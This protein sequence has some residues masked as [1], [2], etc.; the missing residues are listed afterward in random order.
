MLAPSAQSQTAREDDSVATFTVKA[1]FTGASKDPILPNVTYDPN[2]LAQQGDIVRNGNSFEVTFKTLSGLGANKYSSAIAFRLCRD[3]KCGTVYPGS[4]QSFTY[5]LDVALND[6]TTMQRNPAHTGYVH[7][8]FD[9]ASFAK[10]WEFGSATSVGFRPVAARAGT[11]FVSQNNNAGSASVL[12]L[13]GRDGSEQW[14]YSLGASGYYGGPALEGDQVLISSMTV[15]SDNNPMTVL[16]AD[17]GQ[18]VRN[19]IFP[20]QWSSFAQPTPYAG[21]AFIASG[22]YGNIV[23]SFDLAS[24]VPAWT[25][26]GVSGR[27]WDGEAPAADERYIYYYSGSLDLFDRA[28][29]VLVKSIEDPFW[30]WYGYSYQGGPILGS[31]NHVI[32]YSGTTGGALPLV[33]Y[34]ILNGKYR[35]RTASGYNNTPAFAKGVLYA[36]STQYHQFDAIDE[37]SGKPL[38]SWPLPADESF[39]GNVVV[40]DTLVFFSTNKAVYAVAL[41]GK[42]ETKWKAPVSGSLAITPDAKLVVSPVQGVTGA[43]LT[44]FSLR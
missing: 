14:H 29:G 31:T 44:A 32:A 9:P 21:R 13:N 41:D 22:Y 37:N 8:T 12:A 18:F 36:G 17:D 19:F 10:A 28:T 20:A 6:W 23:Y 35:W 5:T 38:W 15:S 25:A 34:D 24:G 3:A 39:L 30:Q 42:H 26:N 11:V 2:L 43:K 1:S 4:E 40:T 16:K 27:I 33:D 7:A